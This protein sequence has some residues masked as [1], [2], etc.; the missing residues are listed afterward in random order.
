VSIPL[1][2]PVE[3]AK[4]SSKVRKLHA[5]SAAFASALN[6]IT[7]AKYDGV[8]GIAHFKPGQAARMLSRTGEDYSLSCSAVLDK[9][10][11]ALM[12]AGYGDFELFVMGEVWRPNCPQPKISGDFRQQ[13]SI[14]HDFD[15]RV[16]DLVNMDEPLSMQPYY[17]RMDR[18]REVVGFA[19]VRGL[20]WAEAVISDDT[21]EQLARTIGFGYDGIVVWDLMG[22]PLD[23]AKFKPNITVD[24]RCNGGIQ[25]E[26]KH[27]G[28]LGSLTF[29]FAGKTGSVGTG[30]SDKQRTEFWR[31]LVAGTADSPSGQI[32][33]VEAMGYTPDG[34]LREPRFKGLRF[35]KKE[36]D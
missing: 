4:V 8:C 18:Y 6:R 31:A 24:V 29:A 20:H 2:R 32:I 5:S 7:L 36:S 13:H 35:D 15:Y 16:F 27:V 21:P 10:A 12:D 26:G 34:Q 30:F 19:K 28:R 14:I 11:G 25:G 33:E 1:T 3:Y 9:L 17:L 23:D 22:L